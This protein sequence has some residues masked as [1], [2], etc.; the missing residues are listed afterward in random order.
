[1]SPRAASDLGGSSLGVPELAGADTAEAVALAVRR[2]LGGARKH[3]P[4]WLFYDRAGSALFEQITTLPEYTLTRT[5]RGI[6]AAHAGAI[7][8]AA[9]APLEVVELGAGT[10]SKTRLL[11][12]A[13]L[14]RQ[15]RVRYVP[16]DVSPAALAQAG[17]MLAGLARLEVRPIVARYPE[18]LGLLGESRMR[19][20]VLLLG[21]NIGN[22]DPRAGAE[23]LARLR[24]HLTPGDAL[25]MGVDRRKSPAL[26]RPAYDDAAGVT[27][28]F[29]KN[30]LARLNAELGARFDLDRF[31]HVVKWNDRASRI[32]LYLESAVAQKVTID[33]LALEVSF[34]AGER[35]HTESSYK[36]TDRKV[37]E[38]LIRGGFSPEATWNDE[39]R[40][41]GDH[42]A[43]VRPDA[44]A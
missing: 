31:R 37:A 42:L 35:I 16:I 32:E 9:G 44:A 4:P 29:N 19:R 28:R 8:E 20:L 41:F 1:M 23:L 43:R 27:A 10:A 17:S 22:Y 34:R 36:L 14:S 6:L 18:G 33:A 13:L 30:V 40:W 12:E 11:L 5:E 25:L 3:L 38:M 2:G 26:L 24:G 15:P 21:S 39:R 7:V